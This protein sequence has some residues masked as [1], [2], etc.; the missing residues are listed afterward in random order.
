MGVRSKGNCSSNLPEDVLWL[1][2]TGESHLRVCGYGESSRHLQDPNVV[3]PTIEG[4]HS[5]NCHC[6]YPPV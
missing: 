4:D 6:R 1:R 2:S 5:V 3:G